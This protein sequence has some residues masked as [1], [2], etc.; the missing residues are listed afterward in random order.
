MFILHR[1]LSSGRQSING[2][3]EVAAETRAYRTVAGRLTR[4]REVAR[5][6]A[7]QVVDHWQGDLD[8]IGVAHPRNREL[9]AYVAAP[10]SSLSNDCML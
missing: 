5:Q 10:C 8:A 9:L 7:F 6:G 3:A 1:I 4:C 2:E